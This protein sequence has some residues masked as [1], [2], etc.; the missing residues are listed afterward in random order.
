MGA[1]GGVRRGDAVRGLTRRDASE[2]RRRIRR[3]SIAPRID[4]QPAGAETRRTG[5]D[6]TDRR[7]RREL[8]RGT[9]APDLAKQGWRPNAVEVSGSGL[10]PEGV[11]VYDERS[12]G[13]VAGPTAKVSQPR[14]IGRTFVSHDTPPTL[15]LAATSRRVVGL[16]AHT[17]HLHFFL[18]HAVALRELGGG[19][20]GV[21]RIRAA[22]KGTPAF[23]LFH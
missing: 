23:D 11:L 21:F 5:P 4:R 2:T 18:G 16:V 1:A 17:G 8:I 12:Q 20:N 9:N 15:P 3:R 22:S 7:N 6:A 19:T 14:Q 10:R 13:R